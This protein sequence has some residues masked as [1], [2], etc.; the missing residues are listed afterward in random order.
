MKK[1]TI[2]Y[3]FLIPFMNHAQEID[4][5][6][7]V[8]R[9]Q[10]HISS[11]DTLA[12]LTVGN[13]HFAFTT[14]ITGLQTF[15]EYYQGGIPLG[16]QSDWGWDQKPNTSNYRFDETLRD[17]DQHDRSVPYAV[18]VKDDPRKREASD[19]YRE[20]PH[21][22]HLANLGF[23]INKENGDLI[24][25]QDLE[26]IDQSLDLWT[27]TIRSQFSVEEVPTA[28][29]T[30]AGMQEDIIGIKI[31]SPLITKNQLRLRLRF[32][33]PSGTWKDTGTQWTG[34]ANHTSELIKISSQ[35]YRIRRHMDSLSYELTVAWKGTAKIREKEAHYF[36]IIPQS[37][38]FELVCRFTDRKTEAPLPDFTQLHENSAREKEKFWMNG[39][40]VDFSDCT[41]PRAAEL[42]R[43]V[44][45]SQYLTSVQCAGKQP[46]QETGLTFNSWFGKPHLEMH[47]WHGVHFAL[48]NRHNLL[49]PS[50]KWYEQVS[51]NAR[52]IAQRQGYEGVR[53]QKMT[54]PLGNE[55]PSSVGAFLI[56]QQP[57]YITFAELMYRKNQDPKILNQFRDL[58]YQ[59]ATF[60][61]SYAFY[62]KKT[63]YYNLG[64]G[65][66][67]AQERFPAIETFNPT[68]EL[69]YWD[70]A[71]RTAIA[72]K[73]RS[74]EHVPEQWQEVVNKLAPLPQQNGVYLAAESAPDSYTNPRYMTDHPSV[75]GAFGMLPDSQKLDHTLMAKTFELIWNNW[76]W[77]ETW[78][79]DF[80]MT[81]MTATRL[82]KPE[83]AIDALLMDIQTNTFLPNGHNFQ[84]E[85]LTLYLP[86]NG[87]LLT[88]IALMCAGWE[89]ND[90]ENP[91]FPK[92][93][94]W[95][96]KWENLQK[97][98]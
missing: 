14:D 52:K 35:K 80:P 28:V 51:G 32:P 37:K 53:W 57:H 59:T 4:R 49:L 27:G 19:W 31:S 38:D 62:D 12:S 87:G 48:W 24:T 20:Q 97:M 78:G 82:G 95:N 72:W 65:L 77:E 63:G 44:V 33:F 9:H 39:G 50:L 40:A 83:K 68:Y 96:V 56:W 73:K 13:G 23:E 43:R 10:I 36:E 75:L 11:P 66:I 74:G 8:T 89:D 21:R 7:L 34:S 30:I 6:A 42:E 93:G 69:Q 26:H 85:R 64:P 61:V 71:L 16:T 45:L 98:F 86:G 1:Y 46:P 84:D 3:L 90:I 22:V 60:M 5:K 17:Y 2:L 54:D 81:A 67:P 29:E 25:P 58:V 70:W 41:D 15:P 92:D 88:A 55:S 79:W 91:G 47:W 18:Q 76:S 94:T